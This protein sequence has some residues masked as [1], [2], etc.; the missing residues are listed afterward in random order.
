LVP[1]LGALASA[2]YSTEPPLEELAGYTEAELAAVP[3]FMVL[4]RGHGSIEW[5]GE[6]DV[7][8]LALE[9]VVEIDSGNVTVYFDPALAAGS[10]SD[11]HGDTSMGGGPGSEAD[12]TEAAPLGG[13]TGA[14]GTGAI[15]VP[16]PPVG[17][18]LNK[19]A[20]ITLH[21]V[22]P[23]GARRPALGPDGELVRPG[24]GARLAAAMR[25]DT[26]AMGEGARFVSY[27][28]RSGTW[29]FRLEEF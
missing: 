16:K 22:W 7:R 15:T 28:A 17:S 13:A 5:A 11:V 9:R 2:G 10:G 1:T 8:G 14:G 26:E 12:D 6:V 4:R 27:D 21:G 23:S 18:G 3:R 29:A 24:D 20:I 25:A 19:P